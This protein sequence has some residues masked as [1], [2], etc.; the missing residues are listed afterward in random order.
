MARAALRSPSMRIDFHSHSN[1]SDGLDSPAQL[2]RKMSVAGLD[3]FALTDHD[4]LAGI[5]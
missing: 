5:P 3:A 1:V 2:A 4:S